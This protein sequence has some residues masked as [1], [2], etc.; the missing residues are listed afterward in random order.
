[1]WYS[2]RALQF[3]YKAGKMTLIQVRS[4]QEADREAIWHI[5]QAVIQ[6]GD[7]YVYSA[8]TPREDLAKL[9]L[10]PKMHVYVAEDKETPANNGI[11]GTYILK[12]NH[13]DRGAHIANASYMVLPAAQGMGVGTAMAYHSLEEA[14]RLRFRAVQFNLVVSTNHAAIHLW[15]KTGFRIIGTIPKAFNHQQLGYVDA[16]IMFQEL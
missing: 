10:A 12:P 5:F 14:R 11:L 8:G 1:M 13:P 2:C 15:K 3:C 7:T 4:T 9:W 6:S 16:Y